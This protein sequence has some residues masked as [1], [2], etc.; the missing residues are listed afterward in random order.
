VKA[1]KKNKIFYV[2]PLLFL[3]GCGFIGEMDNFDG[4]SFEADNLYEEKIKNNLTDERI[5]KLINETYKE[6]ELESF[7]SIELSNKIKGSEIFTISNNKQNT[8]IRVFKR[9]E[10]KIKK[11]W[12]KTVETPVDGKYFVDAI[13]PDEANGKNYLAISIH[14]Q[15]R[16]QLSY[17][18]IGQ[19]LVNDEVDIVYDT[20]FSQRKYLEFGE[21]VVKN[22]RFLI[23]SDEKI[24]YNITIKENQFLKKDGI[25]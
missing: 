2:I 14:R 22:E 3:A 25:F 23:T 4:N 20:E 9:E 21:I 13:M 15:P 1:M 24:M 12:E 5:E 6:E 17:F 11:I 8:Y 18:I 16:M 10:D 19:S 7:V